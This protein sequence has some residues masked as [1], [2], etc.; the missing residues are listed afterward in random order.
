MDLC[1]ELARQLGFGST[2]YTGTVTIASGVVTLSS[3]T[4]PSWAGTAST[5]ASALNVAGTLYSVAQRDSGTQLTLTDTSVTVGSASAYVL[6]QST[7]NTLSDA[8]VDVDDCIEEGYRE[9]CFPPPL[10][11]AAEAF[12]VWS[13]LLEQ[14]T[15]SLTNGDYDLDLPD[16]FQ[17]F[18][19]SSATFNLGTDSPALTIVSQKE[20]RGM[21]ARNNA[22]GTPQALTWRQKAFDA[23]TGRRFEALVYPTPDASYS[24]ETLIRVM[25]DKLTPTNLYPLCGAMHS[26]TLLKACQAAAE[27]KLDDESG[28]YA[29]KFAERLAASVQADNVVK[30]MMGV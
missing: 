5:G 23:T 16:N 13:W 8:F 4:F 21:Q 3:G 30:A 10:E 14:Y 28:V 27:R 1:R 17:Q 12:Y 9:L 19:D 7:T 15:L 20:M 22:S 24:V 11:G 29:A 18:I 26:D 2:Y 25:P 6:M